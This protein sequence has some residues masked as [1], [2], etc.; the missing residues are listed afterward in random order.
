LRGFGYRSLKFA[1]ELFA[2]HP[3]RAFGLL[4]LPVDFRC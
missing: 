1:R 2:A 3:D 4:E